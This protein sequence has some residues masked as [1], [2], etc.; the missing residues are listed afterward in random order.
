MEEMHKT[1]YGERMQS[2]HVLSESVTLSSQNIFTN[3]EDL[4]FQYFFLIFMEA[5]LHK[6]I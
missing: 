6:H 2:F 3:P 4:Q 5:S 1:K